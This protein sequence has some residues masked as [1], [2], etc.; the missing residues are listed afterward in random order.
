MRI[1]AGERDAVQ[2]RFAAENLFRDALSTTSEIRF[3]P[4][5]QADAQG[6]ND[7]V[8]TMDELDALNLSSLFSRGFYQLPNGSRGGTLGEFVRVLFRFTV[9]FR[10]DDGLCIGNDPDS[11][12]GAP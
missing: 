9:L 12:E 8:V 6:D 2:V 11:I 10:T 7:H 5:A 1:R 3:A 4:F